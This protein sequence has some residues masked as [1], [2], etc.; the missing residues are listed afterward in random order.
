MEQFFNRGISKV[1]ESNA[2]QKLEQELVWSE[3]VRC[4]ITPTPS[5]EAMP[6]VEI[7]LYCSTRDGQKRRLFGKGYM[8]LSN[9]SCVHYDKDE[10]VLV[11]ERN[12]QRRL[13]LWFY[14]I[15]PTDE[16]D[17]EILIDS[18]DQ[19]APF[20]K[21]NAFSRS[22][23]ALLLRHLRQEVQGSPQR[24]LLSFFTV[25]LNSRRICSKSRDEWPKHCLQLVCYL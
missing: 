2:I 23:V 17:Y 14:I 9:L 16:I 18:G 13:E 20:P 7:E 6:W 3:A 1:F 19:G 24:S 22:I 4:L 25:G 5:L 21:K 15:P 10:W 12:G 8:D 11:S